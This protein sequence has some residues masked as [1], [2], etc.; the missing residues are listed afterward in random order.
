MLDIDTVL[1]WRGRT[2][3]DRQGEK[4]GSLGDVYLEQ[5]TDRPAFAGVNTGLFGR[6]EH[7]VPLNAIEELQDGD[8]RVPYSREQVLAAPSAEADTALTE[9]QEQA[10][11]EHYDRPERHGD[12][13]SIEMV[14]SEEEVEFS[15][16]PS[17]RAE[18]V[19]LVKYMV[20]EEVEATATVR[21]EVIQL[22]TDPPPEG[23]IISEEDAGSAEER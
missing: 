4:I 12:D 21:R 11:F 8:L 15:V 20:T 14:R 13:E 23:R 5:G 18:R 9:P 1:G 19:R 22:E 7:T 10:L 17:R 2:V 16:R 6:Q 3:R